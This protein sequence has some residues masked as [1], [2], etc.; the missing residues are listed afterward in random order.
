MYTVGLDI[1]TRAYFTAATMIIAIPTGIKIF[2]WI[3]ASFSK[4]NKSS[5]I[6]LMNK[7]HQIQSLNLLEK[8]PKSNKNYLVANTQMYDLVIYG[9]NLYSTT[10]YP[11]YTNIIKN[12]ISLP[13]EI[14]SLIIGLL[15]SDGWMQIKKNGHARLGFKQSIEKLEYFLSI[16]YKLAHYCSSS[17]Y[18]TKSINKKGKI[19]YAIS[20]TTRALPCFTYIYFQ[21]YPKK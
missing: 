14:K 10:H 21:F 7:I 19:F 13:P 9:S 1:D 20:L 16:Y 6:N 4:K 11:K 12:M 15:I 18:L 5:K 8:F 2:S 17:H 3:L